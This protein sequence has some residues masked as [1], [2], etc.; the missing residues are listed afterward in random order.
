MLPPSAF[1]AVKV[2]VEIPPTVMVE[3]F[4]VSVTVGSG[5]GSVVAFDEMLPPP[6]LQPASRLRAKNIPRNLICVLLMWPAQIRV[7]IVPLFLQKEQGFF[8]PNL[9]SYG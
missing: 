6:E 1:L 5:R 7:G 8:L 2:R 3:G 9:S 4:A